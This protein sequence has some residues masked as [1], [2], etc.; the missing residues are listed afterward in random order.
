MKK[1]ILLVCIILCNVSL[2]SADLVLNNFNEITCYTGVS[3]AFGSTMT[4]VSGTGK[5][6][7]PANNTGEFIYFTLPAGFDAN[8]YQFL[9]IS[10]KSTETN[11]RFVPGFITPEWTA[12]EDWTG[13]YRY[14]GAGAWQDVYISLSGMTAGS[15][16]TYDKVALKLASYDSKPSF[17]FYIDNVTFVEKYVA[18]YTKDVIISNFDNVIS[19]TGAWGNNTVSIAA[20]PGGTGNAGLVSV[21]ASNTGGITFNMTNKINTAIHEK[22]KFKIFSTQAFTISL[23]K[24]ESKANSTTNQLIA[25]YLSYN[26]PNKWQEF[27]LDLTSYGAN[28]YDVITLMPMAWANAPAFTFYMDDVMLTVKP[29][30]NIVTLPNVFS[31][32]MVI[33]QDMQVALWGWALPNDN[34]E[35]TAGWGQTATAKAGTDGKWSTKIQT[36]KAIPGQATPYTLTYTGT[37][38][39]VQLSNVLIGDVWVCSGQ[40]NMEYNMNV[41][42]GGTRGVKNYASEIA[43]ANYPNIRLFKVA[44]AALKKTTDNC[45]GT[46]LECNPTNVASFSAVAYYFGREINQNSQ[47]NI[48]IGLLEAAYGGS[49]CE[50]WISRETLAADTEFNTKILAPYDAA[51]LAVEAQYRPTNLFNAMLAPIIPYGIKG[52]LWYQG[53][54][55]TLDGAFYTKLCGT[56]LQ[57]WR[58]RWGVGNF[59]FYYVQLPAY[60]DTNWPSFRDA[61][62]NMLTISN[63]GMALTI[64]IVD[65]NPADVH[66]E[67][68]LEVGQRL[69]KWAL[70][71]DYGQNIIYSGP[72]YKSNTIQGN[73]MIISFH[74]ATIGTGLISKDGAALKEFQIAG[75]SGVF[76]AATAN[77]VGNTV[78]VS[79]PN[80][81]IPA[82][83]KYA[84]TAALQPNL[85][86]NE[87]LPAAPFKTDIWNNAITFSSDLSTV[88]NLNSQHQ[89]IYPNPAKDVFFVESKDIIKSIEVHDVSGKSIM[90]KN[91]ENKSKVEVNISNFQPGIY[92]VK[93]IERSDCEINKK[94]IITK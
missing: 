11:Y 34:I 41:V 31:S 57:D 18:D 75:I 24:L 87:G 91:T 40:S 3:G 73:K 16:G 81:A 79:S 26:T 50:A 56:M 14:T 88:D 21:P 46:W 52:A 80:V 92:I 22:L 19:P 30:Y 74:P 25:Q 15:T 86:N 84:Y 47:V 6:T 54:A 65:S 64:D 59:P 7:V 51:P 72:V 90:K 67:N 76:Y 89:T 2:Y 20:N 48:P 35:I 78:E 83:V 66:P 62:T 4:T 68:K 32:N 39:T 38:N 10:V 58:T 77:I 60:T 13:T 29:V 5:I 94:F 45:D 61:Q 93:V 9:K 37:T 36:P 70:A 23:I 17:D 12:S 69:A 55:N 43:A 82:V 28:L 53:E 44:K 63:T 42:S 71:K 33:Q 85:I 1:V 27:S 49:R 8:L